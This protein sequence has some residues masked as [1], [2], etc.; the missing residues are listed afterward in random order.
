MTDMRYV[1]LHHTDYG[2]AHFDLMIEPAPDSEK[3]LTWRAAHWPA[4]AGDTLSRIADHRRDYLNYEGPVSNNRGR[5]ERV[6]AGKCEF[7]LAQ[8]L[9]TVR[10]LDPSVMLLVLRKLENDLWQVVE[11]E[12]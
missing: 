12:G 4:A 7:S 2:D 3:L 8:S 9:A 6:A 1:V 5:V 10:I 11:T